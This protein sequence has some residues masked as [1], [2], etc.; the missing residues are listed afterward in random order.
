MQSIEEEEESAL[1]VIE[2]IFTCLHVTFD[3][4]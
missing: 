4:Q 1:L 2:Y 3:Q